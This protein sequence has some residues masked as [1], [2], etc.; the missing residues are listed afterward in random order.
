VVEDEIYSAEQLFEENA[1]YRYEKKLRDNE[2]A[3]PLY[4]F[5]SQTSTWHL[6]P[7]R[8]V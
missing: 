1:Y 3:Q 4:F 5:L 7:S 8:T 2:L 6:S